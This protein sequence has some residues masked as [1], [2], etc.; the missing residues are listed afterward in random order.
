MRRHQHQCKNHQSHYRDRENP[1]PAHPQKLIEQKSIIS[2]IIVITLTNHIC[3]IVHCM[4]GVEELWLVFVCVYLI[5]VL[6]VWWGGA[7]HG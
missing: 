1:Q 4:C 5:C 3:Y 7:G 6:C 2:I